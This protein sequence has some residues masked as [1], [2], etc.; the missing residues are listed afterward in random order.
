MSWILDVRNGFDIFGFDSTVILNAEND[1]AVIAVGENVQMIC[2]ASVYN[3]TTDMKWKHDDKL[4]ET[5]DRN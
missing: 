5:S 4:I 3:Y 2:G 1:E